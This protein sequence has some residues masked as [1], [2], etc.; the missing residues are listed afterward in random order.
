MMNESE[1]YHRALEV[2]T[3]ARTIWGEAR[4][5][6][7]IGMQAVAAV[8]H[9]RLEVAKAK[10]KFWWGNSVIEICQKPYQFSCWNRDDPNYRKILNVDQRDPVFVKALNIAR[11]CLDDPTHGATHYHAAGIYPFWARN[12]QPTATLGRHI[13]YRIL[14]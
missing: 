11:I 9:N 4:G 7:S 14:T 6:G 12:Q 2:D 1:I 13:F 3:C 10:G 5:E 8:I